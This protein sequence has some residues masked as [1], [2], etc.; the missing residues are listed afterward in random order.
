MT[1]LVNRAEMR[2][3][4]P[5]ALLSIACLSLSA[6]GSDE[7]VSSVLINI[8][9][10]E[11]TIGG[12]SH[13]LTGP[14]EITITPYDVNANTLY[15]SVSFDLNAREGEIPPLPLGT[16]KFYVTGQQNNESIFGVSTPFEVSDYQQVLAPTIVGKSKC[17]GLL[18]PLQGPPG[19]EGSSDLARSYDGSTAV[20]LDD[21]R[22]LIIGGGT[23][24]SN[25]GQ[26]NAV[27]GDIQ[28]FDPTYG[29][30][31]VDNAQLGVPRAFHH[32]TM[33]DDGRILIAGGV[34]GI[35]A[36]GQ[37]IVDNSAEIITINPDGTLAISPVISMDKPRYKHIQLKLN[38]G[39]VLL[40]GGIDSTGTILSST[41][42]FFPETGTFVAQGNLNTPRV[43]SAGSVLMRNSEKALI[44]G[45][46][47]DSGVLSSTELFTTAPN[48]GCAPTP[49]N[50]TGC[51]MMSTSL[52]RP[53]WGHNMSLLDDGSILIMGGFQDGTFTSPRGEINTLEQY[54][55]EITY[56]ANGNPANAMPNVIDSVGR[57][58]SSRGRAAIAKLSP[59]RDNEQIAFIGG[60]VTSSKSAISLIN[61]K[62]LGLGLTQQVELTPTCPM[63][64]DR[65]R[66]M[67]VSTPEGSIMIFGGIKRGLNPSTNTPVYIASRRIEIIYPS[68]NNLTQ[69]IPSL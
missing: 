31:R 7:V 25:S 56:D 3:S 37:Y 36:D 9:S 51:F 4:L 50:V 64:E 45:G 49:T 44:T 29:I 63:S 2:T 1:I 32:S 17:T 6:C 53:R 34:S 62:S 59:N 10:L 68:I 55:F 65:L 23:I 67:A 28:Y 46:L 14:G 24:S 22:V 40:A 69:A 30:V 57:L 42:R 13:E 21:G 11:Q 35:T 26:L 60:E 61:A 48:A 5:L 41:T 20:S 12:D 54:K 8:L 27:S 66:P 16:W 19:I 38:D 47:S 43:E 18:P 52:N 15:T 58:A 33:L 39:T